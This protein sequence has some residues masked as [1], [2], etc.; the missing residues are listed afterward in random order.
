[1]QVG[2]YRETGVHRCTQVA[3]VAPPGALRPAARPLYAYRGD[4]LCLKVRSIGE[5]ARLQCQDGG[6]SAAAP[7][8]RLAA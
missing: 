4:A 3:D 8:M 5:G 7:P 2:R 6:G 1:M